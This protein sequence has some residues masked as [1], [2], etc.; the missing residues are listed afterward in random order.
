[1]PKLK[2]RRSAAKRFRF[3]ASGKVRRAHAYHRHNF[4][5]RSRKTKRGTRGTT[6]AAAADAKL[7]RRMLP[8]GA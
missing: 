2:T 8:Y 3:T 1:M 5:H 6:I 7:I 4:S